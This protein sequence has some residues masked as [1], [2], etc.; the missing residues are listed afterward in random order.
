MPEGKKNCGGKGYKMIKRIIKIKNCPSFIDFNP[1]NDLP[2]FMK[3]NIIYGWNGSGKTCFSRVL[4][5]FEVG[6]N[7]YEHPERQAEFE[8]KLDN[9]TFINHKDLTVFKNIRVFNEDFIKESVFDVGGP[10]PIFFLGKESKKDKEKIISVEHEL[11][12]LREKLNAEK[13]ILEKAEKN[14]DKRLQEKARDIKNALTT[15]KQDKYRN[16]NRSDLEEAIRKNTEKLKKSKNFKLSDKRIVV[17]KKLIQQ[18]SEPEIKNIPL[19]NLDLSEFE[20]EVKAVLSKRITSKIIK[21]LQA[22]QDVNKWVERGFQIHK[23]KSLGVCAFCN[24]KIP[25]KRFEDLENYFNDEYQKIIQSIK[26]LKDKCH[27]RKLKL[28]FLNPP[29]FTM[30]YLMNILIIGIMQR[31]PSNHSIKE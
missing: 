6:K 8:F 11:V 16:Y 4:R 17:L 25:K 31:K 5:S 2:E 12:G 29:V 20:N 21:E 22:D 3:Y 19:P 14:K 27:S 24:Q 13:T 9:R 28:V 1:T 18:T 26:K 15:T 23:D 7:Y 10:K 30:I